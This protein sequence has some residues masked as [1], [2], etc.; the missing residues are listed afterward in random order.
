[1]GSA[2][3]PV[4]LRGN[5]VALRMLGWRVEFNGL[6]ALQGVMVVYPHTSHWDFIVAILAKWA[7]GLRLR[8]WAKDTLFRIPLFGP[9]LKWVGGVPVV[10]HA[11]GRH[12]ETAAPVKFL[13]VQRTDPHQRKQDHV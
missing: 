5:A 2:P 7:V 4:Q 10:R 11:P 13:S 12:P 9:W 6:P 1:M 3:H 8:F